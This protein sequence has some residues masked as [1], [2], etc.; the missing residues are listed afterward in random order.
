MKKTVFPLVALLALPSIVL[1]GTQ[2]QA[3]LALHYTTTCDKCIPD[4]C[5]VYSPNTSNTPC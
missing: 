5:G 2:D 1:G 3:R 4:Y